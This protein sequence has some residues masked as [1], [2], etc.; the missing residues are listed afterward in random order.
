MSVVP[1][2]KSLSPQELIIHWQQY[3]CLILVEYVSSNVKSI[4]GGRLLT[5]QENTIL[6]KGFL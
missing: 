4:P 1:A 3:I 5:L 6:W 2:R